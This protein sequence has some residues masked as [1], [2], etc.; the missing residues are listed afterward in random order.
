MQPESVGHI[1][2]YVKDKDSQEP[3]RAIVAARRGEKHYY[4]YTN[5]EGYYFM[6][7]VDGGDA[8]MGA[9]KRDYLPKLEDVVV[10]PQDTIQVDFELEHSYH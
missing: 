3:L 9:F 10:K 4:E 6:D 8:L 7:G 1:N 2:G 5:N